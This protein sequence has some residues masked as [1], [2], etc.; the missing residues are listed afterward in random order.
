MADKYSLRVV[1]PSQ[2]STTQVLDNASLKD[3]IRK[4]EE[5]D[6]EH[7]DEAVAYF[8]QKVKKD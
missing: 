4:A 3:V 6:K 5:I 7:G 2:T 1:Y 8:I